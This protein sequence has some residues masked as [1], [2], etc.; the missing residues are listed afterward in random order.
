MPRDPEHAPPNPSPRWLG[1]E[2]GLGYAAFAPW[3]AI[4]L[5]AGRV[6]DHYHLV[7]ALK[8]ASEAQVAAVVELLRPL[9]A[10]YLSELGRLLKAAEEGADD[11]DRLDLW[12][13]FH[14]H[15]HE[16]K[17]WPA[18]ADGGPGDLLENPFR[19]EE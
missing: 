18:D 19:T 14:R 10:S 16:T 1:V 6:K 5:I 7:E 3:A 9:H 8:H 4:K 12:A 15:G 2:R 11:K 17:G 13:R